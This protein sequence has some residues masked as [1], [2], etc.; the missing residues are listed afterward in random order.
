MGDSDNRRGECHY[1]VYV[2]GPNNCTG[3]IE[4]PRSRHLEQPN[5]H[6]LG[7]TVTN[8]SKI[9]DKISSDD[10]RWIRVLFRL[11]K[12]CMLTAPLILHL[13]YGSNQ[14][15]QVASISCISIEPLGDFA[16]IFVVVFYPRRV[17]GNY[18]VVFNN[19]TVVNLGSVGRF[20]SRPLNKT[21]LHYMQCFL[22]FVLCVMFSHRPPPPFFFND[23]ENTRN[24][25]RHPTCSHYGGSRVYSC[26]ITTFG[27]A[28]IWEGDGPGAVSPTIASQNMCSGP[29]ANWRFCG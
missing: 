6:S 24:T 23:T 26:Q 22:C 13:G 19:A 8:T 21:Y 5:N 7:C 14:G 25:W 1:D 2:S 18:C 3:D 17:W 11:S 27:I 9:E 4:Y 28:G 16:D 29:W 15:A 12:Y 10:E 20:A